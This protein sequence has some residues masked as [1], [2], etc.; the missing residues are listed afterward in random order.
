MTADASK[1]RKGFFGAAKLQ[2]LTPEKRLNTLY[3]AIRDVGSVDHPIVQAL[4]EYIEKSGVEASVIQD[5]LTTAKKDHAEIDV[6]SA[7]TALPKSMKAEVTNVDLPKPEKAVLVDGPE[8]LR[9]GLTPEELRKQV[10]IARE[11][12][13]IVEA[14]ETRPRSSA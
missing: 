4:Q 5:I 12:E 2:S 6:S 1:V 11:E 10:I 9:V 13:E 3:S 7:R 14:V 8:V